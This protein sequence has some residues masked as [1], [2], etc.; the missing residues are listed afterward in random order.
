[1]CYHSIAVV[2]PLKYV[3]LEVRHFSFNI[4]NNSR[5]SSSQRVHCVLL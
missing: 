4:L 2:F 3:H 1:M 5:N